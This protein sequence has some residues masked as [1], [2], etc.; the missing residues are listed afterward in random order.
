MNPSPTCDAP[1]LPTHVSNMHVKPVIL[2]ARRI[3]EWALLS[4]CLE[5]GALTCHVRQ[6]QYAVGEGS[7]GHAA[8]AGIEEGS[9]RRRGGLMDG[10]APA[11]G[12]RDW[13]RYLGSARTSAC[14]QQRWTVLP[15]ARS[16][17]VCGCCRG[18]AAED[19]FRPKEHAHTLQRGLTGTRWEG[20]KGR[21]GYLPV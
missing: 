1:T 17:T 4:V 10:G 3:E 20:K 16:R 21:W 5:P 15:A 18:S 6:V 9:G 14:S 11:D 13:R 2:S 8:N 12:C 7:L 19:G